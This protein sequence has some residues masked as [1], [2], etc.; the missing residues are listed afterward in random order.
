MNGTERGSVEVQKR[1]AAGRGARTMIT[2]VLSEFKRPKW[3]RHCLP[4]AVSSEPQ[5]VFQ[6]VSMSLPGVFSR[7]GGHYG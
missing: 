7:L 1:A 2:R 4:Q 5:V 6:H 3:R